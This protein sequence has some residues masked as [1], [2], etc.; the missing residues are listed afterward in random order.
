MPISYADLHFYSLKAI[1]LLNLV[2]LLVKFKLVLDIRNL[3]AFV[4]SW[5]KDLFN[6][7]QN[8]YTQ[9]KLVLDIRNLRT[10]VSSWLKD[11]FNQS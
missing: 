4:S 1:I 10:F 7:S 9:F 11:L 2:W 5:L 3:R 6:Q 8:T